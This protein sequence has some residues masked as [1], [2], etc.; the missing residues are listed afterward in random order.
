MTNNLFVSFYAILIA[1]ALLAPSVLQLMEVDSGVWGYVNSSEEES[2]NGYEY[3]L[4]E[5]L[6]FLSLN[7]MFAATGEWI[8]RP[9]YVYDTAR[10]STFNDKIVLPPPKSII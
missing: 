4:H 6:L 7:E 9:A 10:A 3:E 2:Q 1:I 8:T 5:Q